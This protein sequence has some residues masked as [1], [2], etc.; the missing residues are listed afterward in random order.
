MELNDS[1]RLSL[2]LG[3]PIQTSEPSIKIKQFTLKEVSN[4][5]YEKYLNH[6]GLIT[7]TVDDFLKILV[8]SE[9]YMDFYMQR[10]ELRPFD[11]FIIFSESD[12]SYKKEVEKSLELVLGLEQ[13]QIN[14]EG[15][16]GRILFKQ[17]LSSDDVKLIDSELFDEITTLV[18]VSNG[19]ISSQSDD[20][21]VNPYNE[22]AREI[23]EKMKKSREKVQKIKA[24]ES[25]E[26]PRGLHDLISAITVKSPS[27][28]KLNVLDYTLF[29]IYDEY[30]RLYTI[31][32][33]NL[34]T[35]SSMFGGDTEISDWA[36]PQ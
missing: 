12:D 36:K 10:N 8:D 19:M 32:N 18:K 1:H 21:G 5:G 15:F 35:K 11:F 27:T 22:R 7:T 17:D 13:G 3:M 25:D 34:S 31:E 14:I 33:Y 23:Y 30:S 20:D 4:M 6:V 26:K 2:I 16:S 24:L 28:N 9:M 29:Q